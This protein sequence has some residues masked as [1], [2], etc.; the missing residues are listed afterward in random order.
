MSDEKV[1]TYTSTD[2]KYRGQTLIM[3][4]MKDKAEEAVYRAAPGMLVALKKIQGLV[5]DAFRSLPTAT[6]EEGAIIVGVAL[7]D[8]QK[9]A[10][11]V[12]DHAKE[13][14]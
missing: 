12:I 6:L 10:R 8:I 9:E 3:L 11:D 2:P 5:G 14:A 7:A 13:I 1:F 4:A